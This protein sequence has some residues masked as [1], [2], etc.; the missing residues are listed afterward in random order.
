MPSLQAEAIGDWARA[1]GEEGIVPPDVRASGIERGRAERLGELLDEAEAAD[2]AGLSAL[3]SSGTGRDDLRAALA[4]M[5][6]GQVMRLSHWISAGAMPGRDALVAA[7]I[8][9]DAAGSGQAVA[10]TL[11]AMHRRSLL[12]RIFHPT[13]V[14]AL[15]GACNAMTK[16]GM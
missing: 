4:Q 13:R 16:E 10:A 9:P 5:A 12:G 3:L 14:K 1:M 6:P 7:L 11:R 15:R 2:P 8:A